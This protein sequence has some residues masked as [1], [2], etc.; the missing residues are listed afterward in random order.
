MIEVVFSDSACGSLKMAQRYGEGEY[1]SGVSVFLGY[2]GGRQPTEKEIE[3]ARQQAERGASD[4]G[5]RR[6][7]GRESHGCIRVRSYAQHWGCF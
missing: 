2:V 4:V 3:D 1:Q 6:P 7:L 5:A